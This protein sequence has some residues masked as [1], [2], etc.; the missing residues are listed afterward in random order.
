LI[1][2]LKQFDLTIDITSSKTLSDTLNLATR[3]DEPYFNTLLRILITRCMRQAL[4]I[5]SGT[6]LCSDLYHYGLAIGIF[7]HFTSPI[8][9]YAG[10]RIKDTNKS[11]LMIASLN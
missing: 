9:R 3:N 5:C 8:R 2:A 7:T 11:N 4:Y 1:Q 6:A 10:K